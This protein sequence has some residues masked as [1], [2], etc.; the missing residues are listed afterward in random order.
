MNSVSLVETG[1][2]RLA[3]RL[4]GPHA[5]P[6][7]TH[8]PSAKETRPPEPMLASPAVADTVAVHATDAAWG[9]IAALLSNNNVHDFMH[10]ATDTHIGVTK[11]ITK[12]ATNVNDDTYNQM[13][14]WRYVCRAN[15]FNWITT[16]EERRIEHEA[17]SKGVHRLNHGQLQN[18]FGSYN[19]S[20]DSDTSDDD[21]PDQPAIQHSTALTA[22]SFAYEKSLMFNL[23]SLD[24]ERLLKGP[25][26]L[27]T[28]EQHK[29]KFDE[30]FS[31]SSSDTD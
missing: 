6:P 14:W 12:T 17:C 22:D 3:M 27:L 28:T 26:K 31:S 19:D 16:A 25:L 1:I 21:Q 4:V 29:R 18:K 20:S 13:V 23:S 7:C 9:Q 5:P 30:C 10:D 24:Q 2:T 15:G 11:S 8:A